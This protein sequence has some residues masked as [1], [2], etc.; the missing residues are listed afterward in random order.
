M[1]GS[2]MKGPGSEEYPIAPKSEAKRTDEDIG[3]SFGDFSSHC[4][5]SLPLTVPILHL[6]FFLHTC[7]VDFKL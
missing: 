2:V 3:L 5:S 6:S 4:S 7:Q 1:L